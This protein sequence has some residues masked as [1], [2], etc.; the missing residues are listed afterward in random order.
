MVQESG[1]NQF[2]V[3][4]SSYCSWRVLGTHPRP[5]VGLGLGISS[6]PR[7]QALR[8]LGFSTQRDGEHLHEALRG[9]NVTDVSSRISVLESFQRLEVPEEL[10]IS[11]SKITLS[12]I[13]L[14]ATSVSILYTIHVYINIILTYTCIV[15]IYIHTHIFAWKSQTDAV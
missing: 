15:Y 8:F 13:C 12:I 3:G 9:S 10:D 14:Q 11:W 4:S 5:V 1:E 6:S 2:L 7:C